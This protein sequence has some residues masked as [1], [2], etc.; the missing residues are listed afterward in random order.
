[1]AAPFVIWNIHFDV[2]ISMEEKKL[3]NA[4]RKTITL[5]DGRE[6]MIE[7]GKLAKQADE[8]W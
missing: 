1:M 4:V 6:I 7:T 3:Y 5:A 8:R 2:K